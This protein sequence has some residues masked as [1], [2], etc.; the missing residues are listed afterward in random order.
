MEKKPWTEWEMLILIILTLIL[1]IIGLI[2]GLLNLGAPA[3]KKQAWILLAVTVLAALS[4]TYIAG[5]F[6]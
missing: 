3:R 2:F 1:P 4:V 5:P 6:R